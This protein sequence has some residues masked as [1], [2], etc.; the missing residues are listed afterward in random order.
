MKPLAHV[1][2]VTGTRTEERQGVVSSV[3][4]SFKQG[5][6]DVV[7]MGCCPTGVDAEA[8]AWCRANDVHP[9]VVHALWN[10]RGRKAG[11]DRNDIVAQ[12]AKSAGAEYCVAV[13]AS[14]SVGTHRAIES[15]KLVGLK[16]LER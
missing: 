3:L 7:V 10:T 2:M 14:G 13:P 12:M 6:L 1:V 15:A 8:Y 5:G 9:V 16:V 4:A 11:P